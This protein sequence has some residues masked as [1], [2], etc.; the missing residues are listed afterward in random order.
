[1]AGY[2]SMPLPEAPLPTDMEMTA[3]PTPVAADDTELLRDWVIQD[4]VPAE[5]LE[6]AG[7]KPVTSS[8]TAPPL[9]AEAVLQH[10]AAPMQ[11]GDFQAVISVVAP[12]VDVTART[13][14]R[15][16]AVLDKSGSM[17]GEKLRLVKETMLLMLR[18][19]SEHDALGIVEYDTNVRVAAPLICCDMDGR[20]RLE[21]A[22]KSLCAGSQTNLSGGLLRG[23]ELHR[24]GAVQMATTAA[25]QSPLQKLRFGN[26]YRC[27]SEEEANQREHFGRGP[28]PQ[29]AQWIHEWTMELHFEAPEDAALVQKV[30][31][32]LH[33]TFTIP[34]VEVNE[35][36]SFTL[37][38]IGWGTFDVHA[39]VHLHDGRVLQLVH[40]LRFDQPGTFRTV[41][42]PLRAAP[43]EDEAAA[44]V[45]EE[46]QHAEHAVVRSTFLFTD[47]LANFG[48]TTSDGICA[49]AEAAL[50]ELGDQCC[51]LSTFG[52][53]ADHNADLLKGLADKGNG[54][55]S[56]VE[57]EDQI[58][59]A[60]GEALGGL[61]STT[62]QNVKLSLALSP[63][64]CLAR[65]PATSY[66]VEDVTAK[67]AT[68]API[69]NIDLG[70]LFAEERR[71][72]LVKFALPEVIVAGSQTLGRLH[73]RGFSTL[74]NR[75]EETACI[76]IAVERTT[77]AS[78]E[79]KCHPHV[80]QHRN[81]T[82]AME[83]LEAARTAAN[84]GNLV[85]ARER[86][87]RAIEA[88][89]ASSITAQG[90]VLSKRLLTDLQDCL[91]DLR[92][93]EDY[94]RMGSKKMAAMSGAHG[95]QRGCNTVS[96]EAYTN[97]S[98]RTMRKMFL[99]EVV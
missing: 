70:D 18:H 62:H 2:S 83:A 95:K 46:P 37:R 84:T 52:F 87:T 74:A 27:M 97:N 54:I 5:D 31:Y 42:L 93:Q 15:L 19:L 38:H 86:V 10:C 9:V 24:E 20:A 99:E 81:R 11:P 16:V 56:Y 21:A 85:D 71:D 61:L 64:I 3:V 77:D 43:G 96:S 44:I 32:N 12:S 39:A 45:A 80:Q 78:D 14:L 17:R 6:G 51:S 65:A 73:A 33:D 8:S 36:P 69:F 41:L 26:S 4:P 30:V 50:G 29:G 1:M 91:K 68:A 7:S 92:H 47:G 88:L 82:I 40:G 59:S 94:R 89:S 76:D 63:G 25:T 53:G 23:L 79:D 48:I 72:I 66:P 34:K 75:F 60:F 13:P 55:Y 98:M 67:D 22:L 90:D 28:A 49:A 57:G 58:G 35:G